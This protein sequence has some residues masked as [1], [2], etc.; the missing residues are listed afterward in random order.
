MSA[1]AVNSLPTQTPNFAS[2]SETKRHEVKRQEGAKTTRE[3]AFRPLIGVMR[4][5]PSLKP[6]AGLPGL[7]TTAQAWL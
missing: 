6:P 7:Q 4:A 2:D 5:C 3:D 1:D